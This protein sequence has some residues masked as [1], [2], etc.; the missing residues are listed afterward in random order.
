MREAALLLLPHARRERVPLEAGRSIRANL[1]TRCSSLHQPPARRL[2]AAGEL[3][4][5]PAADTS[6]ASPTGRVRTPA[7]VERVE[8][9]ARRSHGEHHRK[10]NRAQVLEQPPPS[11]ASPDRRERRAPPRARHRRTFPGSDGRSPDN[12]ARADHRPASSSRCQGCRRL[13]A[14]SSSSSSAAATSRMMIA[15][16]GE[17]R[18]SSEV[19][20]A[21]HERFALGVGRREHLVVVRLADQPVSSAHQ[22]RHR[23]SID[24]CP[25]MRQPRVA[26]DDRDWYRKDLRSAWNEQSVGSR[27]GYSAYGPPRSLPRAV[28]PHSAVRAASVSHGVQASNRR[29]DSRSW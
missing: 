7:R 25:G 12:D 10:R 29:L 8:V 6:R 19:L 1:G 3:G 15:A 13:H 26:L 17:R 23:L 9:S 21:P 28:W 11:V 16:R 14:A 24:I 20:A 4:I 18:R 27:G 5:D 2:N 22:Q